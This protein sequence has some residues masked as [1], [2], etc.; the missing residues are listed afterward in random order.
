MTN[1]FAGLKVCA[2]TVDL[3]KKVG[4][5]NPMPVQEQVN[6]LKNTLKRKKSRL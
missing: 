5:T 6:T 4:I 3:L 1:G 2:R